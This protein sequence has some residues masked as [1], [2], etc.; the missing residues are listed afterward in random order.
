MR[1]PYC[2]YVCVYVGIQYTCILCRHTS[3]STYSIYTINVHDPKW[4]KM[5][6]LTGDYN[7][8][9]PVVDWKSNTVWTE[10]KTAHNQ[11]LIGGGGVGNCKFC[12]LAMIGSF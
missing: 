6:N 5:Y 4:E 1:V 10:A 2:T 12:I 3:I 9:I 11:E 7:N 8:T